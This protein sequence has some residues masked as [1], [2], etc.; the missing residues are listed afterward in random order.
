MLYNERGHFYWRY[1]VFLS[2]SSSSSLIRFYG[3]IS[4]LISSWVSDPWHKEVDYILSSGEEGV[5]PSGKSIL[6]ATQRH[7]Y[8]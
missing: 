8:H 6:I 5:L 1:T 4:V 7:Q 2:S 3:S